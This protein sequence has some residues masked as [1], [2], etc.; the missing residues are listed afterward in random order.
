[1]DYNP[2]HAGLE[3]LLDLNG[4]I[5]VIT[6]AGHWV[7]IEVGIVTESD[8][9]PHGIKYALTFHGPDNHRILGYD[10]G[11]GIPQRYLPADHRHRHPGDEGQPYSFISPE[12]LLQ[13]FFR[14]VDAWLEVQ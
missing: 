4:E 13:D 3:G 9:R 6:G 12:R 2:T 8:L 11:H 14:D 5:L 10:N 1:M 7:K